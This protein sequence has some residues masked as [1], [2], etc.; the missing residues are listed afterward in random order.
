M[1]LQLL[2]A[3]GLNAAAGVVVDAK[4]K[5]LDKIAVRIMR[6]RL[7]ERGVLV[8]SEAELKA[9]NRRVSLQLQLKQCNAAVVGQ[10]A[11]RQS[12][13]QEKINNDDTYEPGTTALL[14]EE[15]AI[16]REMGSATFERA[17]IY[18]ALSAM[19]GDVLQ[20]HAAY[21]DLAMTRALDDEYD[22]ASHRE[23]GTTSKRRPGFQEL[24]EKLEAVKEEMCTRLI[25]H[26]L[27]GECKDPVGLVVKVSLL[28]PNWRAS[29]LLYQWT[30]DYSPKMHHLDMTVELNKGSGEKPEVFDNDAFMEWTWEDAIDAE[31]FRELD[32]LNVHALTNYRHKH[33]NL[34]EIDMDFLLML[35]HQRK[36]KG[37]VF[38]GCDEPEH[39]L[40]FVWNR[41]VV[42]EHGRH[43]EKAR[44]TYIKVTDL[45]AKGG[46]TH[47]Q[48]RQPD[49]STV[50]GN[51]QLALPGGAHSHAHSF[52][53][54][55][56]SRDHPPGVQL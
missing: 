15:A 28:V 41:A 8:H 5:E 16:V 7:I 56:C 31:H 38:H 19:N 37:L 3:D 20:L 52:C 18:E 22:G 36:T 49:G 12:L 25:H 48:I 1:A 2:A 43:L 14:K 21:A 32:L 35:L 27:S 6:P 4:E 13:I 55:S 54:Y 47:V 24:A 23:E 51:F 44:E 26:A 40:P 53:H 29:F 46:H 39:L 45:A 33:T 10:H 42:Q 30:T 17:I 34:A 11:E 9:I 50:A